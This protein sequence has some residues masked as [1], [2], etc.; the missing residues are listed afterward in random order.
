MFAECPRAFWCYCIA[1]EKGMLPDAPPLDRERYLRRRI[2]WSHH[3]ARHIVTA[4]MRD[5][6]C[7]GG[8]P[9]IAGPVLRRMARDRRAASRGEAGEDGAYPMW[10]DPENVPAAVNDLLGNPFLPRL[11]KM[12]CLVRPIERV[13]LPEPCTSELAGMRLCAAPILAWREGEFCRFL[14]FE[15]HASV[16]TVLC[17]FALESLKIGPRRVT[18]LRWDGREEPAMR[19]DFSAELDHICASAARM[20]NGDYPQTTDRSV[21]ARC[22]FRGCC[23]D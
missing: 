23:D 21:C 12:L 2:Q 17:R 15:S 1:S 7:Y 11:L 6:F 5:F 19:L 4:A 3:Y 20:Y 10:M 14:T 9:E 22:R 16:D 18:F 8:D 13:R